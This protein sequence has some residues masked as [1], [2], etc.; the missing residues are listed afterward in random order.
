MEIRLLAPL[1]LAIAS[2][3]FLATLFLPHSFVTGILRSFFEAAMVGGLA[4]WFAVVALFDHPLGLPI[5]HTAILITKR[6]QLEKSVVNML[7]KLLPK[8][9][10]IVEIRD[11]KLVDKAIK[12]WN[13]GEKRDKLLKELPEILMSVLRQVNTDELAKWLVA[14]I[15]ALA[16][17][18]VPILSKQVF[19]Y[20]VA[21]WQKPNSLPERAFANLVI[22]VNQFCKGDESSKI[23]ERLLVE[24]LSENTLFRIANLVGIPASQFTSRKLAQMLIAKLDAETEL[25]LRGEPNKLREFYKMIYRN[26]TNEL[27]N[28]GSQTSSA[29]NALWDDWI[30]SPRY[31]TILGEHLEQYRLDLLDDLGDSDS[32]F[33]VRI[34]SA[35]GEFMARLQKDETLQTEIQNWL[36]DNI[37]KIVDGLH[38]AVKQ[39]VER[40]LSKYKDEEFISTIK[41]NVGNDLQYI[42]LNGALIGGLVGL[43]LHLVK[44]MIH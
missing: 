19:R 35:L 8:E 20:L 30:S 26:V 22:K 18:K 44:V 5:P 28:P 39:Y 31:R 42:R 13:N 38:Q 17:Q 3:G 36:N 15:R 1:S 4:D 6:K 21:N 34:S 12:Y 37:P 29:L 2:A 27:K 10:V 25:A 9:D 41:Q 40:K 43:C 33:M 32:Q 16:T 14:A 24:W 23:I 7:D 11:L